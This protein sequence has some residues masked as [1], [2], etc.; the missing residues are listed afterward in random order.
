MSAKTVLAAPKTSPALTCDFDIGCE[1]TL[2]SKTRTTPSQNIIRRRN[3]IAQLWLALETPSV[4][5]DA[6]VAA[7]GCGAPSE[8]HTFGFD[9]DW[10]FTKR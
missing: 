2:G 7:A 8:T 9:R 3:P 1:P 5:R 4:Q 6:A 10:R